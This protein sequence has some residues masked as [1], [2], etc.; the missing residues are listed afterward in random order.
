MPSDSSCDTFDKF[1]SDTDIIAPLP[2]FENPTGRLIGTTV[3]DRKLE[4]LFTSHASSFDLLSLHFESSFVALDILS[5]V[6]TIVL[7][8]PALANPTVPLALAGTEYFELIF[9]VNTCFCLLSSFWA[10]SNNLVAFDRFSSDTSIVLPLAALENPIEP[11][12]KEL[13]LPFTSNASAC[14][15]SLTDNNLL[16]FDKFSSDTAIVFPLPALAKPVVVGH[17]IENSEMLLFAFASKASCFALLSSY[18][19]NM[20]VAFDK[21]SSDTSIVLPHPAVTNPPIE[22]PADKDVKIPSSSS[23]STRASLL[24]TLLAASNFVA[25][26]RF[27]S[28]TE[29]VFP[30]PAL[31]NPAMVGGIAEEYMLEVSLFS[32]AFLFALW[33]SH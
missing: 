5:S 8:L 15:C 11:K 12:D 3:E 13:Q 7:P 27:S 10:D 4:H 28:D 30:L 21:L 19:A 26:D 24:S 29:I 23:A 14:A 20:F 33:S 18:P 6:T 1:S 22:P 16:A 9:A 32:N 31:V 17:T 2:A 25:F